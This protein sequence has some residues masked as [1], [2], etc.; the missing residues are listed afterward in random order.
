MKHVP[1]PFVCFKAKHMFILNSVLKMKVVPPHVT[2]L[3]ENL[4]HVATNPNDQTKSDFQ[5]KRLKF[6]LPSSLIIMPLSRIFDYFTKLILTLTP[7]HQFILVSCSPI[8][9]IH[10]NF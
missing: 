9:Q 4:D 2:N 6:K 10:K 8:M 7:K 5:M 3:L 1:H